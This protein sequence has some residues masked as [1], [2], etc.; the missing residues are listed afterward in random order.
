MTYQVNTSLSICTRFAFP[1][2]FCSLVTGN[3]QKER[4]A[5]KMNIYNLSFKLPSLTASDIKRKWLKLPGRAAL[6]DLSTPTF[7]CQ[8]VRTMLET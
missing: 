3:E 4:I 7:L 6:P 5:V 1:P 2:C 8:Y